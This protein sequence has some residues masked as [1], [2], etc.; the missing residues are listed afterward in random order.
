M[1]FRILPVTTIVERVIM[2]PKIRT[3]V[4]LGVVS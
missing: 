1:D 4:D 2:I 3:E